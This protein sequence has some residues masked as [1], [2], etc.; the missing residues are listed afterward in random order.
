LRVGTGDR[1]LRF[2]MQMTARTANRSRLGAPALMLICAVLAVSGGFV[3]GSETGSSVGFQMRIAP[4][5]AAGGSFAELCEEAGRPCPGC[6]AC[7]ACCLTLATIAPPIHGL[8]GYR[9]RLL[10]LLSPPG[11]SARATPAGDC[12]EHPIRA[13]PRAA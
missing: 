12:R 4:F 8:A 5:L 1:T 6:G 9:S 7:D 13:P 11:R 2:A 3:R 10:A